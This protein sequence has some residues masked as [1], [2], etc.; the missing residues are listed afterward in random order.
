MQVNY[1]ARLPQYGKL[2]KSNARLCLSQCREVTTAIK[3]ME[4]ITMIWPHDQFS[5]EHLTKE[6]HSYVSL[7]QLHMEHITAVQ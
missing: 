5:V 6:L 2:T 4:V 7:I 3:M 1:F